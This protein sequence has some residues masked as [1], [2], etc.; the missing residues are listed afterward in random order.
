MFIDTFLVLA[1]RLEMRYYKQ[2]QVLRKGINK[3]EIHTC[4][5]LEK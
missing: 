5:L 3:N 2:K 1:P 4:E